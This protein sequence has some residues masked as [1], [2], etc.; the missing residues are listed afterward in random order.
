MAAIFK[1]VR[2][3]KDFKVVKVVKVVNDPKDFI[4]RPADKKTGRLPR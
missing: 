4:P 2:G 1:G 3:V